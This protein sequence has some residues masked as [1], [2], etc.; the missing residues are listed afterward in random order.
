MYRLLKLINV[1]NDYSC[2]HT[3]KYEGIEPG[4][5]PVNLLFVSH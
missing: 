2:R 1:G 3:D 4:I 5:E